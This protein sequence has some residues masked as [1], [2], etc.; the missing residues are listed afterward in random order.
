MS[1]LVRFGVSLEKELLDAFDR[2]CETKGYATRSEAIRDL[3]RADLAEK[4]WGETGM[5]GGT[6]TIV[7]DHHK[8]DLARR[9]MSIQHECH[10]I[11]VATLH[12][13]LDHDNCLETL[14]LKGKTEAV[15]AMAQALSA[16][17]GVKYGVFN[18]V[19]NGAELP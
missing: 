9:V 6:L 11:I 18:R 1:E 4:Q 12:V 14:V 10:D 8:H 15:A 2:L 19:P 5:C 7:Y 17:K 13:H 3:I 16:C